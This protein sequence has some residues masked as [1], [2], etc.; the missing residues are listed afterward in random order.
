MSE[1]GT[2]AAAVSE[3]DTA[4]AAVSE[5]GAG[6]VAAAVSEEGAGTV[7]AAVSE[8]GAGTVAAAV[9]E[10]GAGSVA[11]AVSEV[12]T[13]SVAAA[14]SEERAGTAD[15]Q[16]VWGGIAVGECLKVGIAETEGP[17]SGADI[18]LPEG[19]GGGAG[20][21]AGEDVGLVTAGTAVAEG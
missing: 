21:L 3:A 20:T 15:R 11:V 10:V 1:A 6:T 5:E 17:R 13:G 16:E 4:A 8:E 19:I 7:A 9:S 18:P 14:V 2:A 12:G